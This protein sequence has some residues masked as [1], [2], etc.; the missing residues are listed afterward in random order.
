M[1][2]DAG[3]AAEEV[4][5]HNIELEEEQRGAG[6]SALNL[7]ALMC[8]IDNLKVAISD[9]KDRK[10]S[11]GSGASEGSGRKRGK[12]RSQSKDR[13]TVLFDTEKRDAGRGAQPRSHNRDFSA[14]LAPAHAII[15][16]ESN[17]SDSGDNNH[18]IP[19]YPQPP[20]GRAAKICVTAR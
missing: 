17:P 16:S 10:S 20:P 8:E 7:D 4:A 2:S 6:K 19:L 5:L 11:E 15:N 12:R 3:S 18:V 9:M 13:R 1:E 14:G